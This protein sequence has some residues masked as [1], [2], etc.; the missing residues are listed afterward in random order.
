MTSRQRPR[1]EMFACPNCGADVVVGAKACRECGSD[2]DTGWK[3]SDEIEYAGRQGPGQGRGAFP[4]VI[5]V[6]YV[7]LFADGTLRLLRRVRLDGAMIG[8]ARGRRSESSLRRP[9]G[10]HIGCPL[11]PYQPV[12]Q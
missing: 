3:D 1:R 2:A 9:V 12:M 8:D 7:M 4:T 11:Q 10:S 6:Q 5:L